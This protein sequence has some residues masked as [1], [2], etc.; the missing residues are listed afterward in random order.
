M[1]WG[2]HCFRWSHKG[3]PVWRG[4]ILVETKKRIFAEGIASE[5]PRDEN[6]KKITTAEV[7][8]GRLL[9]LREWKE[10]SLEKLSETAL[11]LKAFGTVTDII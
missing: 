4:E 2:G 9:Q 8:C 5:M 11:F 6:S 7:E 3:R 10:I 1:R